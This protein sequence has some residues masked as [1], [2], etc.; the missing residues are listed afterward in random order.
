MTLVSYFEDYM[1]HQSQMFI[2]L[3][4][5]LLTIRKKEEKKPTKTLIQIVFKMAII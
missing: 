2:F 5:I 1:L 4:V 3:T